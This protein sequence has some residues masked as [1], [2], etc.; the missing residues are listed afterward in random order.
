MAKCIKKRILIVRKRKV[1]FF[2]RPQYEKTGRHHQV[3]SS[4]LFFNLFNF[5]LIQVNI[6]KNIFYRK[7]LHKPLFRTHIVYH[8]PLAS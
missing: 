3:I 8:T 6:N 2:Y 4:G 1:L 5:V 7:V